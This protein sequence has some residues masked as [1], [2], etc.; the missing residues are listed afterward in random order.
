MEARTARTARSRGDGRRTARASTEPVEYGAINAVYAAMLAGLVMATR[1]RAAQGDPI[2]RDEYPVLAAATFA[3]SKVVAKEKIGTWVR[4]P[5]VEE[6]P[7]RKPRGPRGRR[8][9]RAMGEL[10]TCSRCVGA[11]SALGLVGLRVASPSAGRIVNAV[12]ATSA[13]ND[14]LH[15]GFTWLTERAD[16]AEDG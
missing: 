9:R 15:A 14:F 8:F 10:V 13:A 1:E 11:W 5:F 3:L 12:L 2:A 7:D 16:D 6:G 4:E